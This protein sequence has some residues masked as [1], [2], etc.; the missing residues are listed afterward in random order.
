MR[1]TAKSNKQT[2]NLESIK[3]PN[4]E[5]VDLCDNKSRRMVVFQALEGGFFFLHYREN[6]EL[7]WGERGNGVPT[8]NDDILHKSP[9]RPSVSSYRRQS[10]T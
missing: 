2:S 4:F 7:W 5:S 8:G 9:L 10:P 3:G 6:T 1:R